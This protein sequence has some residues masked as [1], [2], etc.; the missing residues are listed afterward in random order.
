MISYKALKAM[1]TQYCLSLI[2]ILKHNPGPQM[3]YQAGFCF[4]LLTFE[5]EIAEQINK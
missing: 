5:T 2:E 3:S 1:L 4:W